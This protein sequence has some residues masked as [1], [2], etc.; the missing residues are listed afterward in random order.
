M[1]IVFASGMSR[2]FSTIVVLTNM[3]YSCCMNLSMVF[4][5]SVSP[6]WPCP[7]PMRAV[8]TSCCRK[9]ARRGN[10]LLQEGGARPN[11]IH[12]VM[13][14]IDLAAPAY[15]EFQ[16]R[17]DQFGLEMRHHGLDGKTVLGRSFD[18]GHV[19]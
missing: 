8:G 18:H 17:F 15:F 16:R 7:T 1:I 6:I 3:S 10:K 9:A 5:S 11:G 14:E 13:Q 19:A 2:P 12:P 4:S